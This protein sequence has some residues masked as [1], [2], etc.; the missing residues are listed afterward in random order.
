MI[1]SYKKVSQLNNSIQ[2]GITCNNLT[3][4]NQ[5][6]S[7]QIA[8]NRGH[9]GVTGQKGYTG[10]IHYGTITGP[11]GANITGITGPIGY[12]N[13]TYGKQGPTGPTGQ[14]G[15][16]ISG[17][18]GPKGEIGYS[19]VGPTGHQGKAGDGYTG[20][21]GPNI[22]YTKIMDI[23]NGSGDT[24]NQTIVTIELNK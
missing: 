18:R 7:N 8:Y 23:Y 24:I 13:I 19:Y 17:Y 11:T 9:T 16:S 12:S 6:I 5:L 2:G 20:P 1:R 22:N 4:D 15:I 10:P 21:T 3:I 14:T